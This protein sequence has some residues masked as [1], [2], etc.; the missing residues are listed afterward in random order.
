MLILK[1]IF[2]KV[3]LM[4]PALNADVYYSRNGISERVSPYVYSTS[5][6]NIHGLSI[7]SNMNLMLVQFSY[8]S[9]NFVL[10]S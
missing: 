3:F 1:M 9:K 8:D 10:F 5:S 7:Q 4:L 6:L 2:S